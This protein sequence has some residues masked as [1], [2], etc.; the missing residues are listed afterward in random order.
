MATTSF[1]RNLLLVFTLLTALAL[2]LLNDLV[3]LQSIQTLPLLP[4][5]FQSLPA[6][7][8]AP[9]A[10]QVKMETRPDGSVVIK[11]DFEGLFPFTFLN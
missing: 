9:S 3:E 8:S 2:I 6:F 11:A 10:D 5:S 4:S 7:V 1:L